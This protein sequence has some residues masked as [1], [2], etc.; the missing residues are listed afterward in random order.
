M[1]TASSVMSRSIVLPRRLFRQSQLTRASRR[2]TDQSLNS[3]CNAK[4]LNNRGVHLSSTET[5]LVLLV[6]HRNTGGMRFGITAVFRSPPSS[7][8]NAWFSGSWLIA[9]KNVRVVFDLELF[10]TSYRASEL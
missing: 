4:L 10:S 9:T 6:G 3:K 5:E 2:A 7:S 1:I 8:L